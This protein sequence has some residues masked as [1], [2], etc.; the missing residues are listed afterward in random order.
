MV[1][2]LS[3]VLKLGAVFVL[4]FLPLCVALRYGDSIAQAIFR[5][6]RWLKDTF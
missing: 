3:F 2:F 5:L 1:E 6:E 4:A